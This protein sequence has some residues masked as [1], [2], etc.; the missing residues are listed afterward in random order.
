VGPILKN[1]RL[2]RRLR[3]QLVTAWIRAG[4]GR[5][6]T[7]LEVD[8]R[9]V[10]RRRPHP[11]LVIG[12]GVY[13]GIG[14]IIDVPAG[15]ELELGDGVKIMHYSV[16]AASRSLR[17]GAMTQVA[18]HCS[19]RDADHGMQLDRPMRLQSV[20][21]PTV[22]GADVWIGRGSAVLRGS[23]VGDGVVVGANS[24]VRG[25]IPP[26]SVAVGA[27]ARVVRSRQA[28]SQAT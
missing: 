21:T 17:I 15:A 9:F 5:V 7:G 1:R 23:D 11:G 13:L 12:D 26:L 28:G 8:Q 19:V 4:G 27:P 20:A 14:A 6:G 10:L 22:V 2:R 25:T 3:G 18:E 16:V 24:V